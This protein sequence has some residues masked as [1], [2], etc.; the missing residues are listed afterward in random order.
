MFYD[1]LNPQCLVKWKGD[2]GSAI[3]KENRRVCGA[4]EP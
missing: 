3:R 2:E 4:C 1:T